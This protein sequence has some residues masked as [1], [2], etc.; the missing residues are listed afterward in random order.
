MALPHA[1]PVHAPF[2]SVG[3]VDIGAAALLLAGSIPVI[4]LLR[5]RPL[6]I[7][8]RVHAWTYLALLLTVLGAMIAS[9]W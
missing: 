8:D 9:L 4:V 3:I 5:R 6:P 7:P 1:A 2:L